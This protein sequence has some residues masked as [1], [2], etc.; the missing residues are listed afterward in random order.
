MEKVIEA[1]ERTEIKIRSFSLLVNQ[2]RGWFAFAK[3]LFLCLVIL[4]TIGTAHAANYYVD[5]NVGNDNNPGTIDAPWKTISKLNKS[6]SFQ[7]GD[8]ILLQRGQTWNEMLTVSSSG[9]PGNP[10]IYG[11]YGDGPKPMIDVQG[12]YDKCFYSIRSYITVKDIECKNSTTDALSFSQTGGIF[13]ISVINVDVEFDMPGVGLNGVAFEKG[14]G[15][16]YLS[17]VT[18]TNA[19]NNGIVFSGDSVNKLGNVVVE[20]CFVS[21]TGANDGYTVHEGA[22]DA[23][24]AGSNFTFRNNYAEYCAEQGFDITTGNNIL[25]TGNETRYN[26]QG[27]VLVAHSAYDVTIE[28][29]KS[30]DEPTLQTG[31]A[32]GIHSPNVKLLNSIVEGNGYHLLVIA[33]DSD[34]QV[35]NIEITNN[36]FGWDGGS[37][38]FDMS[39]KTGTVTVMNNI[40][41]TAQNS[42]FNNKAIRFLDAER[43]ADYS[44]FLFDYNTYY[45]PDGAMNFLENLSDGNSKNFSFSNFQKEFGQEQNGKILNSSYTT[46]VPSAPVPSAPVP[47]APVPSAP[48]P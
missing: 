31:A 43:P 6:Y 1:L 34:L 19:P 42:F 2:V 28:D 9:E 13:G 45:S 17:G 32:I 10:I 3:I 8:L 47:S 23:E 22:T 36:T 30:Y 33:Q 27:G 26:S 46:P 14:G 20:D 41:S 4:G 48:V 25:L 38:V 16:I 39:G 40:F 37:S 7:P 21:G 11:A 24:T 18:V 15:D 44:G 12:K 35:G 5:A 29:H